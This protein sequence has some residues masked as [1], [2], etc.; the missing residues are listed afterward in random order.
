[1]PY[2]W[3][4]ACPRFGSVNRRRTTTVLVTGTGVGVFG[5]L[6][7]GTAH[8]ILILP[9][10]TQLLRGLPFALVAGVT[11]AWAHDAVARVRGADRS[12]TVSDSV[13]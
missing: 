9:I 1:V 5:L 8:A 6:A 4:C 10:W 3:R 2:V 13:R 7:F 11:F 12:C